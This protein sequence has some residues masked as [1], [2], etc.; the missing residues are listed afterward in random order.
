[1]SDWTQ[2]DPAVWKRELHGLMLRVNDSNDA[3]PSDDILDAP[4]EPGVPWV[5]RVFRVVDG[6]TETELDNGRAETCEQAMTKAEEA[7]GTWR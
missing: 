1:M 2:C 3:E 5:W 4:V 6:S 7:A